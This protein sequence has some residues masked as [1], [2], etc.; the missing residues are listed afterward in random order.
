MLSSWKITT[1]QKNYLR[2]STL[3]EARK[4][5]SMTHWRSSWN[6]SVL[7]LIA[8]IIWCET[9]TSGM[10]LS[11]VEQKSEKPEEK[12]QLSCVGNL[13][14]ALP[15]QPLPPPFLVLTAQDSSMHRLV[16]LAICTLTDAFLNHKV[17]QMVL[18]DYDRQRRRRGEESNNHKG[19]FLWCNI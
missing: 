9:E 17:D 2:A 6:L 3:K 14:K 7:N 4:S 12:Q 19:T 18:I 16:S 13:E 11:N 1:F 15:H 5:A 8:W 10:K